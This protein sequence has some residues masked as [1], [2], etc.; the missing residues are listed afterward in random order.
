MHLIRAILAWALLLAY[1]SVA[2]AD[3]AN[4]KLRA[5]YSEDCHDL[6]SGDL[7]SLFNHMAPNFAAHGSDG[8]IRTRAQ[9]VN[10]MK[11]FL[12][13]LKYTSCDPEIQSV[14]VSGNQIAATVLFKTTADILHPIPKS[15]IGTSIKKGDQVQSSILYVDTWTDRH[16]G[17]L[18]LSA[19]TTKGGQTAINGTV[20]QKQGM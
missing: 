8:T 14:S 15:V 5:A 6:L 13:M 11:R 4:D 2:F 7:T 9:V 18:V 10:G 16:D 1:P 20:V 12:P 3:S 19:S 17:T